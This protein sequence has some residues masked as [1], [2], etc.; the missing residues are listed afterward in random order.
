VLATAPTVAKRGRPADGE[1]EEEEGGEGESADGGAGSLTCRLGA[2]AIFN[3]VHEKRGHLAA[4][5]SDV[6]D[7][8]KGMDKENLSKFIK[9][10][11][12]KDSTFNESYPPGTKG[13]A[14]LKIID[15]L[16]AQ[17]GFLDEKTGEVANSILGSKDL[18]AT[19]EATKKMNAAPSP[20]N[21]GA[22]TATS[23]ERLPLAFGRCRSSSRC[24]ETPGRN[25][26]RAAPGARGGCCSCCCCTAAIEA[27][28]PVVL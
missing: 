5:H 12:E 27:E 20:P 9:A 21:Q 28:C 8:I 26:D 19:R 7:V 2:S 17:Y 22:A 18:K 6:R 11:A 1:E 24:P 15:W 23:T 4:F 25:C 3:T 13:L 16:G 14:K 10:I